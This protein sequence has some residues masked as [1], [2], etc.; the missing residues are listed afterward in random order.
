[1]QEVTIRYATAADAALL[2]ELGART[3]YDTF[4]PDNTSENMNTYLSLAFGPDKQAAEIADPTSTFFLAEVNGVAV[5]YARLQ[6]SET[7]PEVTGSQPIELGRL[8]TA[9][10]WIGH[11]IGATLMQTCLNEAQQRG[12]QTLWLG[13]WEHNHRARAFYSKWGFVEVGSHIF[14]LGDDPQTDLLMQ[15]TINLSRCSR[16]ATSL[17]FALVE[18]SL[19]DKERIASP[20]QGSRQN[21][22]QTHKVFSGIVRYLPVGWPEHWGND[23]LCPISD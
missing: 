16:L 4:A 7:P 6:S 15:R 1:M 14:T 17:G 3:F 20:P 8:Y 18:H 22:T 11:G 9:W 12:Y 13:V 10:E 21:E 5:G 23:C 19:H 2:A